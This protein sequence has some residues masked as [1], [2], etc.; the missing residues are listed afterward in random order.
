[1][2]FGLG[3]QP[4][5]ERPDETCHARLIE[6]QTDAEGGCRDAEQRSAGFSRHVE[7]FSQVLERLVDSRPYG[8]DSSDALADVEPSGKTLLEAGFDGGP[9]VQVL[10]GGDDGASSRS[11]SSG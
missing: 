3:D 7:S 5:V 10:E 1:M 2:R 11:A 6:K 4:V 8:R 9:V